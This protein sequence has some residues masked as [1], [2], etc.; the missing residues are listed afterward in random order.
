MPISARTAKII[1]IICMLMRVAGAGASPA[2]DARK[3]LEKDLRRDVEFL[4]D[5]LCAGRQTGTAGSSGAAF[6]IV[7]R[8]QSLGYELEYNTFKTEQEA[9]GRN[10]VTKQ[11]GT[12][13]AI[14]LMA[15]YDGLGR[16]GTRLY[17]GADSNASGVAA[18]LSLSER[19]KDR[20]DVIIAFVDGHNA[21]MAGAEALKEFLGK[22]RIRMVVSLDILGATLSPPDKFWKNYLI[23]LGGAPWQRSLEKANM[24]TALHLYYDYYGSRSF[25]DLF[26]RKVSDHKVFLGRG[27]PVLM[28]TSG[29][30]MNTNREGD[31]F[32]SLDYPVFAERV[33]L[34][35]NWLESQR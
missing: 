16:I 2:H 35:G 14:L 1:L 18:L 4:S 29:I 24:E 12:K 15:S 13:P 26:Y 32:G 11:K 10:L 28:F 25:T 17:P 22:R 30:T 33:S 19:L 7:R 23:V 20:G 31:T 6:Y 9:L 34:I 5:S 3:A 8:L 27:I 21:N